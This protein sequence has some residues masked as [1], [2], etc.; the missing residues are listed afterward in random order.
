MK[1]L[2]IHQDYPD[3]REY[4]NTKAVSNLIEAS[5]ITNTSIEH[6]VVSINRTSN[7]LK[8]SVKGF[9][10]GISIVYWAL[11][12]PLIYKPVIWFWAQVIAYKLRSLNFT[13]IHGHKL[14]T[15]GLF[16]YF[17]SKRLNIPYCVSVRG[18]TDAYNLARLSD[19]KE[20]FYKVYNG[21]KHVFWVSAWAKKKFSAKFKGL[22]VFSSELANICQIE[23]ISPVATAQ[24][25]RYCIILSYHQLQRKGLFPL[26]EAMALLRE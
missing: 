3:G 12:L 14:T 15:E 10:D 25:E 8:I 26:L 5:R 1:V 13:L 11:P 22:P 4:P 20:T 7:P 21:A 2:H 24:R 6:F 16:S 23:N 17:L 9:S 19:L 18:G